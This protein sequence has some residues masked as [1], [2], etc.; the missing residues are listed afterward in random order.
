MRSQ[1][2][3]AGC[4]HGQRFV[5]QRLTEHIEIR[6]DAAQNCLRRFTRAGR[7]HGVR[8]A[9]R[10]R[11]ARQNILQMLIIPSHYD[12][13]ECLVEYR[14]RRFYPIR[15][16]AIVQFDTFIR[17]NIV[18]IGVFVTNSSPIRTTI[19]IRMSVFGNR[20]RIDNGN[21]IWL[22][23]GG[24]GMLF[25]AIA[26]RGLQ[27]LLRRALFARCLRYFQA[28]FRRV[29]VDLIQFINETRALIR[30]IVGHIHFD[31]IFDCFVIDGRIFSGNFNFSMRFLTTTTTITVRIVFVESV[32]TGRRLVIVVSVMAF[33]NAIVRL[34]RQCRRR[35]RRR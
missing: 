30:L 32:A 16:T 2:I 10:V 18:G 14:T 34:R 4:A 27:R 3:D 33:V 21:I 6:F 9:D 15:R 5:P 25:G 22:F 17:S 28:H 35:R 24:H 13:I 8:T 12:R 31:V 20:I 7:L 29:P 19:S 11:V 23:V 26:I 1:R